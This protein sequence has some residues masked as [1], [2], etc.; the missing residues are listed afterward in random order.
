MKRFCIA[1]ATL[2]ALAALAQQTVAPTGEDPNVRLFPAPYLDPAT[3]ASPPLAGPKAVAIVPAID[4]SNMAAVAAAY[5]TYYN[6]AMPAVGFTGSTSTCVPGSVSLAFQEWTIS[7]INFLRA[8]AGVSGNTTLNS[9]LDAQQQAAALI[10]SANNTLNHFPAS[11]LTC[12]TQAGADGAGTSNLSLGVTDSVQI[13]M[14]EPGNGNQPVG[15]RRWLLDSRKNSF[16]HG[17]VTDGP[18]TNAL[19]AFQRGSVVPVPNGIP[20]PPRGYVPLALF[21]TQFTSVQRWSF[22]LPGASF[23]SANVAVT[24]NGA[25]VTVNVVSRTDNGYGDNTIVWEMPAGHA[26]TAGSTYNVTV[27]GVAGAASTSYTYQIFPFDPA[28]VVAGADIAVTQSAAP[29]AASTLKDL[30]Y[31]VT[32]SNAGGASAAAVTLTDTLPAGSSFVWAPAG[33]SPGAGTVTCNLGTLAPGASRQLRIVVRPTLAT[34]SASNQ[35]AVASSTTE[36]TLANNTS[37]VAVAVSTSP[38][39]TA[40]ARYRL[41]SPV[42]LEHHFTTN[43]HEYNVLGTLGWAQEGSIGKV[44]DNPGSFNGVAA[45]PYYRLYCST[46]TWH[47]WTTDANEYYTLLDFPCWNGEGIDGYILPSA[48]SGAIPLHRL[49]LLGGTGL[50]HWTTDAHEVNVLMGRGWATE[51]GA[52]FLIQ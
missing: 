43:L 10:M 39:P 21:P 29:N 3:P 45:V 26:V 7:R 34:A 48:A 40:V 35:V 28:A 4:T 42:T 33:C 49:V 6:V 41:Y 15:H 22:G 31:T 36:T 52:G 12:W 17:Q 23:A 46:T 44:L 51:P 2:S 32:V 5:N 19:Y 20:W 1:L 50:H 25:P 47:H 30:V 9:S 37:T 13:Y 18:N 27:S 24:R 38:A 11:N 16:G 8:M 14:S